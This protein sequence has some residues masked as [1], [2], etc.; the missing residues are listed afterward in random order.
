MT[1]Y[2]AF[3][4]HQSGP[5]GVGDAVIVELA[6]ILVRSRQQHIVHPFPGI[7]QVGHLRY[8]LY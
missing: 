1:A 7:R 5:V 4:E 8:G 3:L 2:I 6:H